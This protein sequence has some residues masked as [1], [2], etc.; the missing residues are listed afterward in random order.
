M[1]GPKLGDESLRLTLQ[2][3]YPRKP[4]GQPQQGTYYISVVRTG[5]YVGVVF[6]HG[7]EGEPTRS[8]AILDAMA[9]AAKLLPTA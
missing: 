6:D 3:R 4:E 8:A 1:P 5:S 9:Q 7:W 2:R